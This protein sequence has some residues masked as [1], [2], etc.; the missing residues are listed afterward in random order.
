M[1]LLVRPFPPRSVSARR[2]RRGRVPASSRRRPPAP[3]RRFLPSR[4]RPGGFTIKNINPQAA[5]TTPDF[6]VGNAKAKP[7]QP[8]KWLAVEVEFSAPPPGAPELQ[9]KYYVLIGGQ[10]LTGQVT[11]VNVPPGQTLYSIMYVAPRSLA[12]LLKGQPFTVNS[13]ANAEVQILKPGVGA[14]V[15]T[16]QLK[17]GPPLSGSSLPQVAGLLLNKNE[18]PYAPLYYD[19][20][21]AIKAGK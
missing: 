13:V 14:P 10:L 12:Q 7:F 5:D 6:Q 4:R 11:H 19:R 17:P 1:K 3:A 8:G 2:C 16:K 20:Y 21:E 18:T 9:F 15:A